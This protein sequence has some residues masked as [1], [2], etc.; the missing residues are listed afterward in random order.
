MPLELRLLL[1]AGALFTLVYF[2]RQIQKNRLQIDFAIFWSIFAGVLLLIGIFPDIIMWV[3]YKLGFM[4]PSN[5]V[6]LLMIFVLTLKLFS[7]TVKLSRMSRQIAEM[8]Q[9]IAIA[10]KEAEEPQ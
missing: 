9:H 2:L 10:E 7:N 5:L 3:S 6:F 8:A 1:L 4:S